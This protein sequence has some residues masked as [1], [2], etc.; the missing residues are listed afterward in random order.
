MSQTEEL[1]AIMDTSVFPVNECNSHVSAKDYAYTVIRGSIMNLKLEPGLG[2]TEK[3]M[4]KALGISP[5]PVREAFVRLSQERLLT[6][7]PQRGTYISKIDIDKAMAVR[8]MRK[9]LERDAMS[10]LPLPLPSPLNDEICRCIERQTR[11]T[12]SHTFGDTSEATQEYMRLDSLF[13]S[14]LFSG[15]GMV[16]VWNVIQGASMDDF[17]LG[18]LCL[19]ISPDWR[20][21]IRQHH[22][23]YAAVNGDSRERLLEAADDH[24][25]FIGHNSEK[26]KSVFSE[27]F[28]ES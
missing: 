2:I 7:A 17:R 28:V 1:Q 26:A 24:L 15:A 9:T 25:G 14:L 4:A 12:Q 16:H 10:R 13:H 22:D 19:R 20:I 11:W 27:Y 21:F 3:S 23:I 8:Y 18:M 6:V 5:T